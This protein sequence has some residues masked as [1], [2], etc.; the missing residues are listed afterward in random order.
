MERRSRREALRQKNERKKK[1]RMN[2]FFLLVLA[3]LLVCIA[4]VVGQRKK[5]SELNTS[6]KEQVE[7]QKRLKER[8]DALQNEIKQV[9]SLEY[10]EK[11]AREDLGM[12]KEN[13]KIYI[14]DKEGETPE[15]DITETP[16]EGEEQ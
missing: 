2:R 7:S 14:Q 13:E 3:L 11:K 1:A 12:I 6:Y 5:I 10:I 16:K 15:E 4:V 8:V 9:N